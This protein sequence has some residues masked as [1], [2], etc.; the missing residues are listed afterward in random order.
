MHFL[1]VRFCSVSVRETEL[2]L[3]CSVRFGQNGKT[4]LW[5]VTTC[6]Q[7]INETN[8]I[9]KEL[10]DENLWGTIYEANFYYHQYEGYVIYGQWIWWTAAIICNKR[11]RN[12]MFLLLSK[13]KHKQIK[14]VKHILVLST[15]RSFYINLLMTWNNL[16]FDVEKQRFLLFILIKFRIS[17]SLF[18]SN[19]SWNS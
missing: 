4:P 13:W 11:Y 5:S 16:M 10:N 12:C 3:T 9:S 18:M 19:I 2:W 14:T 1:H 6:L 17:D 15:W 7:C 8:I